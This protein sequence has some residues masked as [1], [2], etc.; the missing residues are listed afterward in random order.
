MASPECLAPT[1]HANRIE[2]FVTTDAPLS[3]HP[4]RNLLAL[5]SLSADFVDIRR[6]FTP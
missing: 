2:D 6:C 5:N 3:Q 4:D 1:H